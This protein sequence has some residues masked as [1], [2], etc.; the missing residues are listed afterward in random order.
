[1]QGKDEVDGVDRMGRGTRVGSGSDDLRSG[2]MFTVTGQP[3]T[4]PGE[5]RAF[6]SE[7]M[8]GE[9]A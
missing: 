4:I 7:A 8:F 3:R 1:M 5:E 6:L 9:V 2:A